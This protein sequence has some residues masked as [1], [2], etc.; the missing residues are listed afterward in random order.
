MSG[1]SE[2]QCLAFRWPSTARMYKYFL[3][4]KSWFDVDRVAAEGVL[5]SA[6]DAGA[7]R[8]RLAPGSVRVMSHATSAATDARWVSGMEQAYDD[9]TNRIHFRAEAEIAGLLA[10][11]DAVDSP[12]RCDVARWGLP[13]PYDGQP[14]RHVRVVGMPAVL[15]DLRQGRVRARGGAQ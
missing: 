14:G 12:A 8:Q 10:G 7:V 6:P 9:A 3:R 5:R 4:G 15:P 11:W 13:T 1:I 2:D